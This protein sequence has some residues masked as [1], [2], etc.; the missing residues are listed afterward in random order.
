MIIL[1]LLIIAGFL[2]VAQPACFSDWRDNLGLDCQR[3]HAPTPV[4]DG[5]DWRRHFHARPV[6]LMRDNPGDREARAMWVD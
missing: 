5:Y 2:H 6:Q 3:A 4:V 1:P